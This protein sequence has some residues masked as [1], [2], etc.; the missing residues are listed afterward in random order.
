[1]ARLALIVGHSILG[2]EPAAG[3]ERRSVETPY[4]EVVVLEGERHVLLQRHGLDEYRTAARIDHRANLAAVDQLGCNRILAVGSVGSLHE[5]YGTGTFLCPD[6][7]IALQLGVSFSDQHGGERV[8]AFDATWRE[9]ILSVWGHRMPVPLLDGGVYW[10]AIGPRFETPAEIRMIA[11]HAEVIGM[12]IASEC[13]L[14]GELGI[15][16]GAICA[17]DNLA[18]GIGGAPLAVEDFEAGKALNRGRL[19]EGLAAL[20]EELSG[21][22]ER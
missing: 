22:G 17:V 9:R 6:D 7:F 11:A 19:L 12:T 13:V 21:G 14:A 4:G 8:P 2:S 20:V 10:Q 16:Y 1:M 5:R 3:L 15:V 18:N